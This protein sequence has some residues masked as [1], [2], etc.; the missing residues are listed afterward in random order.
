MNNSERPT[1]PICDR[2]LTKVVHEDRARD[3]RAVMARILVL[4]REK[5]RLVAELYAL[6]NGIAPPGGTP[7]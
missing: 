3:Y 4:D 2:A 5:T 7:T 6:H 1:C